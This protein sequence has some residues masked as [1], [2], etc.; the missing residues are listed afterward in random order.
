M[1]TSSGSSSNSAGVLTLRTLSSSSL[2]NGVVPKKQQQ[3]HEDGGAASTTKKKTQNKQPKPSARKNPDAVATGTSA[4][5]NNPA[6]D[7]GVAPAPTQPAAAARPATKKSE[8]LPRVFEI[9]LTWF[10]ICIYI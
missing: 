3:P 5:I 1:K 9:R 4:G 8:S 6:K 7:N 2:L 10:P